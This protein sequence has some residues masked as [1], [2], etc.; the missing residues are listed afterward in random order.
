M[1]Y[2]FTKLLIYF[3][4]PLKQR[5]GAGIRTVNYA[6][7]S[8]RDAG[9]SPALFSPCFATKASFYS[10][11]SPL[12]TCA[13][14]SFSWDAKRVVRFASQMPCLPSRQRPLRPLRQVYPGKILKFFRESTCLLDSDETNGGSTLCRAI[15][16]ETKERLTRNRKSDKRQGR[17]LSSLNLKT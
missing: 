6:I 3:K 12:Y 16:A 4:N 10:S 9:F 2:V 7:G 11:Y 13:E 14:P 1:P 15:S 8:E 17:F 5:S